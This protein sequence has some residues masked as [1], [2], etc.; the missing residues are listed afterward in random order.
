M[1]KRQRKKKLDQIMTDFETVVSPEQKADMLSRMQALVDKY[2]NKKIEKLSD[3]TGI[4]S[5]IMNP[6]NVNKAMQDA[7][8]YRESDLQGDARKTWMGTRLIES[9]FVPEGIM[10]VNAGDKSYLCYI[11]TNKVH[12]IPNIKNTP[13]DFIELNR[14]GRG[15]I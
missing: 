3:I 1:N 15:N 7:P 6:S 10:I 5:I 14:L 12:E 8:V 4:D 11:S 2:K 13:I 9:K